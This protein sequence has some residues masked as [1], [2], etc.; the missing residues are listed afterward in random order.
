MQRQTIDS[1]ALV[2]Q[3]LAIFT[4]STSDAF[5]KALDATAKEVFTKAQNAFSNQEEQILFEQYNKLLADAG[6][7]VQRFQTH[8]RRMPE[9][10]LEQARDEGMSGSLSLVDD[11]E[12]EVSLG[13]SQMETQLEVR[14]YAEIFPLE[15]RLSLLFKTAGLD[16]NNMPFGPAAISWVCGKTLEGSRLNTHTKTRVVSHLAK[17][18]NK[19]AQ[20]MYKQINNLLIG[21]GILP[22]YKPDIK[23][24]AK[25]EEK[26][27]D[28]NDPRAAEAS[29]IIRSVSSEELHQAAS[30]APV[31]GF[32]G[33]E[34]PFPGT[35]GGV[36]G[37]PASHSTGGAGGSVPASS[38][39]YSSATPAQPSG[40]TGAPA[41]A[42][43]A[44]PR[45]TPSRSFLDQAMAGFS[46]Q[47]TRKLFDALA[48]QHS[49]PPPGNGMAPPSSGFIKP[50][51]EPATLDRALE[52][53]TPKQTDL[54]VG[55][56]G[57]Q[58]LKKEVLNDIKN[59][60][61][62]FYP[63]LGAYEESA[64]DVMGMVLDEVRQT[65]TIDPRV[66]VSIGKVQV[67]L[68]R[69]A[70][71]EPAFFDEQTHPARQF[72]ETIVGAAQRWYGS[73]VIEDL[74][75]FSHMVT[76]NFDGSSRA[77]AEAGDD[78]QKFLRMTE[79]KSRKA[80]SK[81][82]KAAQGKEKLELARNEVDAL[83]N[84]YL[85]VDMADFLKNLLEL[86]VKD[87]MTLTLLR[88]GPDSQQ[89]KMQVKAVQALSHMTDPSEA[90][91]ISK[92]ER[93]TVIKELGKM[94]DQLGFSAKDKQASL[95]NL[96]KCAQWAQQTNEIP[97][98]EPDY[99]EVSA[100]NPLLNKRKAQQKKKTI[101][102]L[103]PLNDEEN[104][105]LAKLRLLPF[106]SLFDFIQNQQM[107]KIR[108]KL[109]WLSPVSNKALFVTLTGNA[110]MER[111]LNSLAIDMVRG[112]VIYVKPITEGFF[113]RTLKKIME[114][115]RFGSEGTKNVMPAP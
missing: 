7:L 106:G 75:K 115:L 72:L 114:S 70:I 43:G 96:E 90:G 35:P 32:P 24:P 61:G 44:G 36:S 113:E 33:A 71:N 77:F 88:E 63:K 87:S 14:Q 54:P 92:T 18:M 66:M 31:G 97:E 21:A 52:R 26:K 23:N 1:G 85:R 57:I 103:R 55:R 108:Y 50:N 4:Q 64:L 29:G 53:F 81:W 22:N 8:C 98:P 11:E 104:A 78:L 101:E 95:A 107:D 67:P 100:F 48:Q 2:N 89:W 49:A 82:V 73:K 102:E 27:K 111:S 74:D 105:M 112:T 109:S 65:E 110:P 12:L 34:R 83:I 62:L 17:R 99:G 38:A 68:V 10:M 5:S 69:V 91:Q 30:Q 15:K 6:R 79:I 20:A 42:A 56:E 3:C 58:Q 86:V 51:V 93:T 59:Q 40:A 25:R 9:A 76:H 13:F 16:K 47:T 80:E 37:H 45:V 19:N 28:P 41:P 39:G 46:N 60:T 84:R 94:M